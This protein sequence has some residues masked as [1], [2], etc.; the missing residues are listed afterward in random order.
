M[1]LEAFPRSREAECRET[2]MAQAPQCLR[3]ATTCARPQLRAVS[4]GHLSLSQPSLPSLMDPHLREHGPRYVFLNL[5]HSDQIQ[6]PRRLCM[7]GPACPGV[8]GFAFAG[9]SPH[10]SFSPA[11]RVTLQASAK[12]SSLLPP[13]TFAWMGCLL[14]P[15]ICH[16]SSFFLF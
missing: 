12:T 2:V 4:G 9:N 8:L 15:G 14:A 3:L 6:I 16:F 5:L 13:D 7:S 11:D 1:S 10:G